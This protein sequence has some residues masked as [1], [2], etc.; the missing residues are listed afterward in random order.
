MSLLPCPFCGCP[1]DSLEHFE[2]EAD[3]YA[4][5]CPQCN[6]IGPHDCLD[7]TPASVAWNTRAR[8]ACRATDLA[9]TI[10]L[11]EVAP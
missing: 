2:V 9:E 11:G 6:A 5:T 1:G 10:D 7:A 4:Y 3:T 8:S